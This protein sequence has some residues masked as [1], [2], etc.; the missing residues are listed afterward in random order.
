MSSDHLFTLT[1]LLLC[2]LPGGRG[3]SS[4]AGVALCGKRASAMSACLPP[5]ELLTPEEIT[6]FKR[7]GFVI[8]YGLLD[9]TLLEASRQRLWSSFPPRITL[10]DPASW[11]GPILPEE[12]TSSGHHGILQNS[13]SGFSWRERL[14]GGEQLMLDLIPN[15]LMPIAEQLIGK[16]RVQPATNED[17]GTM[18]GAPDDEHFPRVLADCANS[19]NVG[20]KQL[21]ARYV[22][23]LDVE[24][25]PVQKQPS[26][27]LHDIFVVGTR[28]RGTYCTL[29]QPAGAPRPKEAGGGH[30][31]AHPFQLGVEV[32]LDAVP[33]NG[34]GLQLW[35]Q[36][37]RRVFATYARQHSRGRVDT[38]EGGAWGISPG[39]VLQQVA[40]DTQPVD[41]YG[42]AGTVV[43]WHHRGM[44]AAGQNYS[45]RL[46][47]AALYEFAAVDIND[48]P[49]PADMWRDCECCGRLPG[50]PA[51]PASNDNVVRPVG[52]DE[53]RSTSPEI[54]SL[55][56]PLAMKQV[57]LQ[58]GTSGSKL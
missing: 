46:R 49:P 20:I 33:P 40:A 47:M 48:G 32:Y 2:S 43:L 35:P 21:C 37:H 51:I 24:D 38:A 1:F 36:A 18:L 26:V 58:A 15:R 5:V 52:S 31:D 53:V 17:V 23:L 45:D 16:G 55:L 11:V 41:T 54:G 6:H 56:P 22:H 34:G 44:H 39:T 19:S 7:E 42:P 4:C 57:Q 9:P 8:K 25:F 10:D 12:E 30:N 13:R 50:L 29:P 27:S 14:A 28:A 3:R